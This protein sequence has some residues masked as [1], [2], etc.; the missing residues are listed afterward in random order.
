VI[1]TIGRNLMNDDS[2][3]GTADVGTWY[4]GLIDL[5]SYTTGIAAGDTMASH[6]GWIECTAYDEE[7]RPEWTEGA[8]S[9][10]VTT[11]GSVVTFTI[12]ATKTVKG[13]FLASSSTK[14]EAA[15]TLLGT[16]L[17]NEGDKPVVDGDQCLVTAT[18]S[19]VAA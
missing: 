2:V 17:F 3:H 14:G 13:F 9:N 4:V 7:T 19:L 5:A 1:T 8:A 16:A 18:L 15:S 6:A 10:G 12:S 11:N